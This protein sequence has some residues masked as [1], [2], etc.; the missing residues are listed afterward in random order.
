MSSKYHNYVEFQ[1]LI[2]VYCESRPSLD[3]QTLPSHERS[4]SFLVANNIKTAQDSIID[5]KNTK[6]YET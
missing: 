5:V 1:N 6:K 3:T 2:H 4:L